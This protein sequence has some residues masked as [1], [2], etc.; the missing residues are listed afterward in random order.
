MAKIED[1]A[2][3]IELY[4]VAWIEFQAAHKETYERVMRL[5]RDQVK[6][7]Q[8]MAPIPSDPNDMS[9]HGGWYIG[10]GIFLC[11]LMWVV[12]SYEGFLG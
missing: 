3:T 6:P 9:I 2:Y 10:A 1:E 8:L 5:E 4:R 11:G 7:V 12:F